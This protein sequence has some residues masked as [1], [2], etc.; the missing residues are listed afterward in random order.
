VIKIVCITCGASLPTGYFASGHECKGRQRQLCKSER[1][2]SVRKRPF[3]KLSGEIYRQIEPLPVSFC[4]AHP[5]PMP[6]KV[7][8]VYI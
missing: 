6:S 1:Q 7:T 3:R 5:L 4:K 2:L 8:K